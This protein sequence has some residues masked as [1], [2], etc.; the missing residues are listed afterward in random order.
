MGGW[1][2]TPNMHAFGLWEEEH[3]S[4]LKPR[5]FLLRGNY[6]AAQYKSVYNLV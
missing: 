1:W 5:T 6:S 2:G 3:A 4:G